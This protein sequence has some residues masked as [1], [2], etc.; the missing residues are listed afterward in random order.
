[1]KQWALPANSLLILQFSGER[2]RINRKVL[3]Q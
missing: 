2:G 1:M 3:V